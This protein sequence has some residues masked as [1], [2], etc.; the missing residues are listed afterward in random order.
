MKWQHVYEMK[1]THFL[2]DCLKR[3]M[4]LY[5][6]GYAQLKRNQHQ[7]DTANTNFVTV[8]KDKEA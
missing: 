6:N 8:L 2:S 3:A 5:S 1:S 7:L 4:E